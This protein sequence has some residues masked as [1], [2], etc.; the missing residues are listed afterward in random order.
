VDL[1]ELGDVRTGPSTNLAP[2]D[3]DFLRYNTATSKWVAVHDKLSATQTTGNWC[4]YDGTDVKCDRGAPKQCSTGDSMTWS[5][6]GS[7]FDCVSTTTAL[8]LG[9]MAY[10]NSTS[11]SI[12]GG[13]MNGVTIGAL[14][15]KAGT[16]TN[17]TVTGTVSATAFVG[18]GSG[19]TN[20][21]GSS[22]SAAGATGD[23][24]FK[25]ISGG[26]SAT[27]NLNWNEASKNL[28]TTGTVQVAGSGAEVCDGTA[29]GKMRVVDVGSGDV[30]MQF[31][32]P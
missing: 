6:A 4:Y 27:A 18:D 16:F 17:L 2:S 26:I 9:T 14:D 19:L 12:T 21:P 25:G 30:R 22:F 11:V 3:K 7:A 13:V 24:Q 29:T 31:C 23:V 1:V 32:R 15:P 28:K 5:A 8:G 10:Q 20:I